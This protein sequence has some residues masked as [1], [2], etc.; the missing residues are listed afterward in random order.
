MYSSLS[1]KGTE[2]LVKKLTKK[3]PGP[4][5]FTEK[6]CQTL[7][8]KINSTQTVLENRIRREQFPTHFMMSA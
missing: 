5:G 3:T 2:F 8:K 6:I 1:L 4:D 7:K